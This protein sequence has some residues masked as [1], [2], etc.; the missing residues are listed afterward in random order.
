M[1]TPSD[2]TANALILQAQSLLTQ[3]ANLL[4]PVWTPNTT[5]AIIQKPPVPVLGPAP[6]AF[7]DPAFGSAITRITDATTFAGSSGLTPSSSG[8]RTWSAD[9]RSFVLQNSS[10]SFFLFSWSS[11]V[12]LGPFPIPGLYGTLEF[13]PITPNVVYGSL[14]S[15]VAAS[16]HHTLGM[17]TITW[18]GPTPSI[19]YANVLQPESIISGFPAGDTYIDGNYCGN[20]MLAFLCG[21]TSQG[22]HYLI[23]HGPTA[24]M[25]SAQILN[26]L[27]APGLGFLVHSIQISQDGRYVLITP[28]AGETSPPTPSTLIYLWDTQTGVVTPVTA[29]NN[30][31]ETGHT[32]MGWGCLINQSVL[33]VYDAYQWIFR[34]LAT[35]NTGLRELISPVLT[36]ELVYGADHMCWNHSNPTTLVPI[37]SATYRY[38]PVLTPLPPVVAW[39]AWDDEIIA[40]PTDGLGGPVRR[41][42]HHRSEVLNDEG[43]NFWSMPLPN[44]SPDGNWILWNSTWEGTLGMDTAAGTGVPRKDVFLVATGGNLNA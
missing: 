30:T 4:V 27:T 36:P 20:G 34:E 42:A 6:F 8:Q 2:L 41:F 40:V 5:R 7:T 24:N 29:N 35:P 38:V 23:V 12:L 19:A 21:G 15:A 26:T 44:V 31:S 33:T 28:T 43:V 16:G 25:A 11:G 39:R 18:T 13:D 17:A 3:A 10:G 1:T 14:T 22:L 9:S 32:D 37:V